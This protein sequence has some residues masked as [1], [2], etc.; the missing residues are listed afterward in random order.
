MDAST[1]APGASGKPR[2]IA[3]VHVQKT[4]GTSLKFILKNSFGVRHCDVNPV[5]PRKQTFGLDDLAFARSANP[6]LLSI[7]GHEISE[8][9]RHLAEAVMPFTM[10]RDPVPR[11]LSHFQHKV[12]TGRYPGDFGQ[13]VSEPENRNFQVRKIAGGEDLEKAV[14][15]LTEDYF[16]VG[17]AERFEASMRVLQALCPYRMNVRYRSKNVAADSVLRTAIESDAGLMAAAREANKLD[18]RLWE[19]VEGELFP[20]LAERAGVD[21]S[22]PVACARQ[23]GFPWRFHVSRLYHRVAYRSLL[24][25]ERRRRGFS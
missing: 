8:P 20:R 15:L 2:L 7:S 12:L 24:K 23:A 9:T 22:N 25:R 17:I 11:M 5:D 6:W 13:F 16:F 14:R 3:F 4:A 21:P 19:F 10:L 18:R 1:D